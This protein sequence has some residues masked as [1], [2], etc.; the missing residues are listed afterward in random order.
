MVRKHHQ[1]M[2]KERNTRLQMLMISSYMKTFSSG[3][4]FFL[5]HFNRDVTDK[6]WCCKNKHECSYCVLSRRAMVT[7]NPIL[8]GSTCIIYS[9]LVEASSPSSSL[10][11]SMSPLDGDKV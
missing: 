3:L 11:L 5:C 7:M 10:S 4:L 2:Y 9:I 8:Q 6:A 1:T